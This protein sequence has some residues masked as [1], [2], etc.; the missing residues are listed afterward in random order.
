M[1]KPIYFLPCIALLLLGCQQH[2]TPPSQQQFELAEKMD[3]YFT[4]L[5]ALDKFNG[6]IAFSRDGNKIYHK[7]FNIK[8]D[9]THSLFVK[10]D[11]QFDIHSVSK[12]MAHYLLLLVE[13]DGDI[14]QQ[15]VL[16]K[17]LPD[18][19]RGKDITIEMLLQHR[20]GLPREF[21][22]FEGRL[23]DLDV[24]EMVQLIKKEPLIFEPGGGKQYSNLGYQLL[25][26]ILGN[27]KNTTFEQH[28]VQ[29]LFVP[30][31]MKDS[32]AH[33]H[34]QQKNTK[35]LARNHEVEE[36]TFIQ[37]DNVLEDEFK[38]S[39]IYSTATDLLQLLDVFQNNTQAMGM[40]KDRVIQ[41]SGGSD[42]VRAHVYANLQSNINF[43]LLSNFDGIPFE[44]TIKDMVS[45]VE[46]DSY[47]IPKA[48]NRTSI[49]LDKATLQQYKG[50]YVFA[51]M[52]NLV[53]DFEV[54]DGSLIMLQE[55]EEPATLLAENDSTFFFD[56]KEAESFEFIRNDQGT[57]HVLM[58]WRGV[59]LK[60]LKK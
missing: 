36:D 28:L 11:N 5:T 10:K 33:F 4:A 7:A 47:E 22:N 16:S 32:G 2:V 37:I 51:D 49:A 40:A 1:I 48:L 60:G 20:S 24:A 42:G 14:S 6:V 23:I 59:K 21:S 45:M 15:D 19:P 52:N 12:I 26:Y 25:Y 53:L 54:G 29:D 50:T 57:H 13:Q 43:V 39:R 35:N 41:H 30:L 38:Q 8:S 58:G 46:G 9:P 56:P 34:T 55:G 3:T 17:F 18:F 27:L 31:K 44:Q